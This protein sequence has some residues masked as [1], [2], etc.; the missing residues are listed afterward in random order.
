MQKNVIT[1]LPS[2]TIQEVAR[3]MAEQ[4]IGSVPLVDEAGK[5]KGILTDRDIA[6]AVAAEGRD[7]RGTRASEIMT[8]NPQFTEIDADLEAALRQ[9]NKIHARRLPVTDKGKLVG[10]ISS[11]D[12][13]G[14]MREQFNQFLGLE[15]IYVRQ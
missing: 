3:K 2:A 6:L 10:I 11:A 13:A 12:V 4:N 9:M 15:E 5:L 14:A 7:P 1:C 8:S